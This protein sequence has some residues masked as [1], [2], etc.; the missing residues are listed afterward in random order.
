MRTSNR[1]A[2][3]VDAYDTLSRHTVERLSVLILFDLST[4]VRIQCQARGRHRVYSVSHR[5]PASY[6]CSFGSTSGGAITIS[7]QSLEP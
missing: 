3:I 7:D 1:K 4:C 2:M 5:D 6:S